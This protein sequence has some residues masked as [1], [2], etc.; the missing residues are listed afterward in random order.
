[1]VKQ[2]ITL[3][4]FAGL[5]CAPSVVRAQTTTTPATC[6]CPVG[7]ARGDL[8]NLAAFAPLGFLGAL[9]AA[10][11][12]PALFTAA[13]T[14][15]PPPVAV[16]PEP[17]RPPVREGERA[18]ESSARNPS[19][20]PPRPVE[21]RVTDVPDPVSVDSLRAGIRAPNTGTPLPAAFLFGTSLVAIG[22][23]T[24]VRSRV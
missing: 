8:R 7:D 19:P 14:T 24:L 15:T 4:A 11:G 21:P 2:A 17:A 12:V 3:V 16:A 9:A 18:E 20:E 6:D 13:P 1:M 10:G 23:V 22:C 5:A